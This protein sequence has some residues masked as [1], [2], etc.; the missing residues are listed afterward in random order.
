MDIYAGESHKSTGAIYSDHIFSTGHCT[1][2]ED[3][4]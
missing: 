3:K 1:A 4:F 2:Q